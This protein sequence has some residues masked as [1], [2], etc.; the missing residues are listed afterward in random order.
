M[1]PNSTFL[2]SSNFGNFCSLAMGVVTYNS[3]RVNF[4]AA[5]SCEYTQSAL[6]PPKLSGFGALALVAFS[7]SIVN[8]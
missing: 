5:P 8:L 1:A 3:D 2:S 6:P 4:V 7:T